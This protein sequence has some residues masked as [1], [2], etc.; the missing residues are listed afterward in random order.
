MTLFDR[1][2]HVALIC[3]DYERSRHFYTEILG[4]PVIAETYRE[5]RRSWKLDL[6]VGTHTQLELFSFPDAPPRPSRPEAQGLRHLAFA[7]ADL[8]AAVAHLQGHGV[9]TEPIRTDE[10]T[11]KRFTFFADPDDLPLEIYEG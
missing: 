3:A 6:A 4:L 7:V 2:H 5:A 11:G 1:L 8:E 9:I 10:L